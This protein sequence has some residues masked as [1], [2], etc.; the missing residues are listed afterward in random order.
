MR[1]EVPQ[2]LFFML[3]NKQIGKNDMAV[4]FILL[5]LNNSKLF[6]CKLRET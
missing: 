6:K 1:Q 4:A 5:L 3:G 2:K